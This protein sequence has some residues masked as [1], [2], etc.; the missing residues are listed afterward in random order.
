[1]CVGVWS[2]CKLH[3]NDRQR[4]S[5][6]ESSRSHALHGRF[7]QKLFLA[8]GKLSVF[9]GIFSMTATWVGGGYLNGTAEAVY[10][11]GIVHCYAPIGYAVSLML[12]CLF[13]K[14]MRRANAITMLDPFQQHYGRWMG[15]LLCLPAVCGEV[16]WTAAMLAALGE[17]ASV[18]WSI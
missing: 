7:V 5:T 17:Q 2:G 13:A 6:H 15:L 18:A 11:G 14:K 1:M 8:D 4:A 3:K 10:T 12:G 9:L 16:F